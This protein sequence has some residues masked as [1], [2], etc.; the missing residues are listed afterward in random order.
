MS[1]NYIHQLCMFSYEMPAFLEQHAT[2]EVLPVQS[3]RESD[4]SCFG[5]R[6]TNSSSVWRL[7]IKDMYACV[8]NYT[9]RHNNRSNRSIHVWELH[10]PDVS[11]R[12]AL[13]CSFEDQIVPFLQ[14][15]A[16]VKVRVFAAALRGNISLLCICTRPKAFLILTRCCEGLGSL[17]SI[18]TCPQE[19]WLKR[20]GSMRSNGSW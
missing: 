10:T 17:E 11:S 2:V 13:C 16:T 4:Y 19:R 20:G 12:C 15:K 5:E 14:Q 18:G 6:L 1:R 8:K 7:C 9:K 3:W